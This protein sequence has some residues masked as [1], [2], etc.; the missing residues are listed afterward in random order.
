ML[1]RFVIFWFIVF[2]RVI[3]SF[4]VKK[5]TKIGVNFAFLAR[6]LIGGRE[7][8]PI[9]GYMVQTPHSEKLKK[10]KIGKNKNFK[11]RKNHFIM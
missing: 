8:T 4:D 3:C 6:F 7:G 11:K 1:F 2:Y 5:R 10:S 9:R